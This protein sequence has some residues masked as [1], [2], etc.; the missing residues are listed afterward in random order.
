MH[1]AR[2]IHKAHKKEAER[3]RNGDETDTERIRLRGHNAS[4][5]NQKEDLIVVKEEMFSP[6]RVSDYLTNQEEVEAYI[7]AAKEEN[8]PALLDEVIKE[9]SV[10]NVPAHSPQAI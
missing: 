5:N 6:Y 2:R 10:D 3:T 8:D 4:M 9:I 7:K 1:A